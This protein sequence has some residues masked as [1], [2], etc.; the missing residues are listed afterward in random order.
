MKTKIIFPILLFFHNSVFT[1]NIETDYETRSCDDFIVHSIDSL[2]ME[3]NNFHLGDE[4]P[5]ILFNV[6]IDSNDSTYEIE[7]LKNIECEFIETQLKQIDFS[8]LYNEALKYEEEPIG[9]RFSY[10]NGLIGDK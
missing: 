7:I 5:F 9:F 8:C 4:R 10:K 6:S 3:N 2:L 1:Q